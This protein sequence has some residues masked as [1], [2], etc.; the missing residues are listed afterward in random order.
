MRENVCVFGHGPF[1]AHYKHCPRCGKRLPQVAGVYQVTVP[2][3]SK[4]QGEAAGRLVS[5][6]LAAG[7]CSLLFRIVAGGSRIVWQVIDPRAGGVGEGIGT[8]IGAAIQGY[9]PEADVSLGEGVEE[10]LATPFH[11]TLMQHSLWGIFP[12]PIA[13]V[14]EL[15]KVDP[16]VALAQIGS[17]LQEDE[18][19]VYSLLVG[20]AEKGVYEEGRREITQSAITPFHLLSGAGIGEALARVT[21]GHTRVERYVP[22]LQRAYED[23]LRQTLYRAICLVQVDGATRSRVVA[24][25][26]ALHPVLG[27]FDT[28]YNGIR[29]QKEDWPAGILAVPDGVQDFLTGAYWQLVGPLLRGRGGDGG[30]QQESMIL[31]A[32]EIASLWHLPHEGFAAPQVVWAAG[33]RAP[34]PLAVAARQEGVQLGSNTYQGSSQP[35]HLPYGDRVTHINLIGR[36][37]VGKSTLLQRI[38]HEDIAQ[39]RGVGV[40]DPHGD[41]VQAILQRS[42]PPEREK[43]VVLLDLADRDYPVGLNLLAVPPGVP[44]EA[45]VSQALG[46]LKRMFEDQ[47]SATRM[48]DALYSALASLVDWPGATIRDV[49]RLF[50]NEGYRRQVLEQLTD[51]VALEFWQEEY[52]PMSAGL[53]LQMVQP[54][55]NRVRRFYRHPL[56]KNVVCQPDSLDFRHMMDRGMIFLASLAGEGGQSEG[57]TIGTALIS[58]MQLAAMARAQQGEAERRPFYLVVDEVQ[59]FTTTSLP[60]IFSEAAKYG[61][62]LTVAN[63]YL[64]QLAGG[65][66]GAIMGNTGT[67]ILFRIGPEDGPKLAPYVKP[68]FEAADLVE[69]DRFQTVVKMQVGGQTVPAF[70]MATLPP[71]PLPDDAA[72]REARLRAHSRDTYARSREEVEVQLGSTYR[73]GEGSSQPTFYE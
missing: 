50:L 58:K 42:I 20:P 17:G 31:T 46:I 13:Q 33:R 21:W 72:E 53:Q 35:V 40:I 63:Q 2:K 16:L 69:L 56:V 29:W 7:D 37:R 26:Q 36:T 14:T 10:P 64:G 43:D 65:T 5:Q 15:T 27:Q 23:K 47:W 28:P 25:T 9:Y 6:L 49:P 68:E 22:D 55:M 11:R 60:V 70:S 3:G 41:L 34:L 39:G 48:E 59:N 45:A 73:R 8:R 52:E 4:W 38:V 54:I 57:A 19:V 30:R 24:L 66:L 12:G 51:D 62:S 61:L 67:T 18:R 44:K 32:E 1:P 71:H